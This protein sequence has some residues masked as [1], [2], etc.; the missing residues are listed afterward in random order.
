[1]QFDSKTILA[2]PSVRGDNQLPDLVKKI[3]TNVANFGTLS[4]KAFQ[5]VTKLHDK[6]GDNATA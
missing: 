6:E 4:A 1:M 2:F 5:Q 3:E